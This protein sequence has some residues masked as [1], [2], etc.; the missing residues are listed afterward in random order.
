MSDAIPTRTLRLLGNRIVVSPVNNQLQPV[1]GSRLVIPNHFKHDVLTYVVI[2]VGPGAWVKRGK[3]RVWMQPECK[4]GDLV[5][6]NAASKHE[7]VVEHFSD[8]G[9][10]QMV[11]RAEAVLAVVEA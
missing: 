10:G 3:K 1:S 4:V 11:I 7:M 5:L 8:T 2:A 9:K 6:T